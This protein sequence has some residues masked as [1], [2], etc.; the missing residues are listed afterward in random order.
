LS[1]RRAIHAE[2][3]GANGKMKEVMTDAMASKK[4]E[5]EKER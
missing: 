1:K 2:G 3:I 5:R 4:N